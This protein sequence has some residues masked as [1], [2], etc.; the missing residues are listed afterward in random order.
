MEMNGSDVRRWISKKVEKQNEIADILVVGHYQIDEQS[1]VLP[2][3]D[4]ECVR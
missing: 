3:I 1:R 4:E 2:N